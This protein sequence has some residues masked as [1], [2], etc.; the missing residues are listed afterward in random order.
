MAEEPGYIR[1]VAAAVTAAATAAIVVGLDA[2]A[3]SIYVV[4]IAAANGLLTTTVIW[5]KHTCETAPELSFV[6][7]QHTPSN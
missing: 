4:S 1:S 7:Q 5:R 6:A 3:A 2:Q